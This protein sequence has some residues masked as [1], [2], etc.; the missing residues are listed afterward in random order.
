VRAVISKAA[1][2][3]T[4]ARTIALPS[5]F[6]NTVEVE[7]YRMVVVVVAKK[8]PPPPTARDSAG[9]CACSRVDGVFPGTLRNVACLV[10]F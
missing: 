6:S 2:A 3:R 7:K 9:T 1:A 5:P 8:P 4:A 10:P